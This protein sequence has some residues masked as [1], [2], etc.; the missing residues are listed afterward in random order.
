MP[1]RIAVIAKRL[2]TYIYICLT[3]RCFLLTADAHIEDI[4]S[5]YAL[6][7]PSIL[8]PFHMPSLLKTKRPL[9]KKDFHLRHILWLWYCTG[10]ISALMVSGDPRWWPYGTV[11]RRCCWACRITLLSTCGRAAACWRSCTPG[12]HCCRD[13]RTLINCIVYSGKWSTGANEV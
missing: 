9:I 12:P 10:G 8:L 13:L 5:P 3:H 4:S 2:S 6:H 7:P 11:P 1:F